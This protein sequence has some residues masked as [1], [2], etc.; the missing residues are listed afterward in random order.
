ML[1]TAPTTP[2]PATPARG[3]RAAY[4]RPGDAARVPPGY[5][6]ALEPLLPLVRKP[7]QYVG[8]EHNQVVTPWTAVQ[9]RWLLCYPDTYE[10][11]QPNQGIQILYELLNERATSSAERLYAPWTDLEALMREHG[12]PAFS[13]EEHRPVWA[14]DVLGVSLPHELGHTNLLNLLDL[15]AVPIHADQRTAEDPVVLVGGHAAYNPEPLAP[16]IDA[17]VMGDGEQ[18][19]L[20]IDDVV[21]A[22][23]HADGADRRQLL[24]ELARV[25]GV[26]VPAFYTPRYTDD[27]RLK[28]TVP[29]EPGVPSIVPKRTIQDLEEWQYPKQQI[30][31]MTETVHERFSVEIFRGCTRGCRFCQAGMITRPVRE[32]RP[33]T[34]QKLV[35]EGVRNTGFEEVGLLSLSSADH[36]AIGPIARDLADAY[37][38][39]VTSLSLPS[40]R[41]DAFNVTLSNELSRNGRRTGLTFAPEAGSERMR[42]VINKMVSEA[43][44]LRTAETA[45]SEGWRHIKLYFMVGLPTETD[46]DVLAIADLGI[47]TYEVARRYGRANKVT[48]SVGGFVPK[49][50]TPFQWA[51]QDSPDEIRRK[52]SLIRHAI[53]DHGNLKLRTNDP[54]E[55]V[56]EGLLARGDR[57]VAPAVERAWRLGARFDGWHEMPTL[58][59]WQQAMDETGVSLDWF[60]YRERDENEALPWDHLDSGLE[61]G[62]L[63]EDWQDARADKQLDDCRWSPCYDCG[64]CPGLSIEHDTGYTGGFQLPV[65][66]S[67]L[68]GKDTLPTTPERYASGG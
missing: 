2:V 25:E 26:Y 55:G 57:R 10:V 17:A 34:V 28:A 32:R 61:K 1:G 67:G 6:A 42:A 35:E 15:G 13:L 38:G 16:F 3:E 49:P 4:R 45:F 51:P 36:S 62:W 58:A 23:K 41:V 20:E 44:L 33:E 59:T 14:F 7:A 39:T 8:G 24:R 68:G 30:V 46:E 66:P 63:W 29:T 19:T 64:V 65:L 21:R 12:I 5:Y 43:D 22:W 27:G 56:I 53:K 9:T 52:L 11:G 31:P 18:V 47:K 40:T 37:E 48:I 54:E 50:H 60:S